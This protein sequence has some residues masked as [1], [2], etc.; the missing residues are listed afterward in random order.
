[1]VFSADFLFWTGTRPIQFLFATFW[2]PG[3]LF[4]LRC[5]ALSSMNAA[6]PPPPFLQCPGEPPQED[7]TPEHKKALLLNAL[8]IGGLNRYLRVVEDEPQP[9]SGG[10]TQDAVQ[11][12]YLATLKRLDAIYGEQVD[13]TCL[14]AAFKASRQ[15]PDESAVQFI[16]EVRRL[17]RLCNFGAT[18][19]I[20]A[21]DQ[22][23][24]GI[25]F[26]HLKKK[27]F[28]MGQ[29][30]TIQKALDVAKE[31]ERVDRAL[32]QVSALT[33]DA[34]FS[35]PTRHGGAE[36]RPWQEVGQRGDRLPPTSRRVAP[37]PA[38]SQAGA[39]CSPSASTPS[40]TGGRTTLRRRPR[41]AW[42]H[43]TAALYR[44]SI[45]VAPP[46]FDIQRYRN[47]FFLA[48]TI[49]F[50]LPLVLRIRDVTTEIGS[51][52]KPPYS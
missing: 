3:V 22:I 23:V 14:R 46:V 50:C 6:I 26:P 43:A 33:I 8:G 5:I 37:S 17:A 31:E 35:R 18:S 9:A 51:G 19:D 49:G 30:F 24:A 21:F 28:K 45:P 11:N 1:M 38:A 27:L 48:T 10:E 44:A 52:L 32:Q 42:T 12:A 41:F 47:G 7:A 40:S 2:S 25:A 39:G 15:G 34:V 13:P 16:L 20:L 4:E 36:R 29:E